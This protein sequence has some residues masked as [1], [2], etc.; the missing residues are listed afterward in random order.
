[1]ESRAAARSAIALRLSAG[2][3]TVEARDGSKNSATETVM[4]SWTGAGR[5]L[6]VNHAYL[7]DM[8]DVHP[9]K[10]CVFR[11]GKDLGKRRSMVLLADE[12]SGVTGVISQMP[13]G[14]MG[15]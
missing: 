3:V 7:L 6:T 10:A 5:V 2:E 12:E 9:S 8:L 4:A 15:Y 14:V 1:M 11:I 13:P